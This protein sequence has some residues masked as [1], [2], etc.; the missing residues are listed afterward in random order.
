MGLYLCFQL[1]SQVHALPIEEV[2]R[3]VRVVTI[4]PLPNAL[5]PLQG[6]IDLQ[7]AI[8]PVINLRDLLG[9][10]KREIEL[11]DMMIICKH[12]D[13]PCA[14]LVDSIHQTEYTEEEVVEENPSVAFPETIA[15]FVKI[16]ERV[17]PVYTVEKLLNK[18]TFPQE[19]EMHH[20]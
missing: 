13:K 19:S 3:I 9:H 17:V 15:C 11:S 20:E 10:E 12:G 18:L 2:E 7:G 16:Q 6:V 4:R 5:P 14:L 1:D 8:T